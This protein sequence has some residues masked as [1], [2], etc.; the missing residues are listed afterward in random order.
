MIKILFV[1]LLT[2][3]VQPFNERVPEQLFV[4]TFDVISQRPAQLIVDK[5]T[6]FKLN[7]KRCEPTC[8]PADAEI[9]FVQVDTKANKI[10]EIRFVTPKTK[11]KK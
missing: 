11:E 3:I 5:N 1:F 8:I 10:L 2:L 6:V 9:I 4:D 7:G